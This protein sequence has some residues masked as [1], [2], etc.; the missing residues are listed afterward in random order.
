MSLKNKDNYEVSRKKS[1]EYIKDIPGVGS[2]HV[3][4]PDG[5]ISKA[6]LNGE[7]ISIFKAA[8]LLSNDDELRKQYLEF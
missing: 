3:H 4:N 7:P 8:T 1:V 6:E 5:F 2:L